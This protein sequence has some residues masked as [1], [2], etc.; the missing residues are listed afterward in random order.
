M[1]VSKAIQLL[2]YVLVLVAALQL[3][4]GGLSELPNARAGL[5]AKKNAKN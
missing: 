3:R 5:Q 2:I 1:S 4:I